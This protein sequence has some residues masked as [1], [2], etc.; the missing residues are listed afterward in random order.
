M[1]RAA[2]AGLSAIKAP[3]CANGSAFAP[4]PVPDEDALT[5]VDP[6]TGQPGTHLPQS[7]DRYVHEATVQV[8]FLAHTDPH[9]AITPPAH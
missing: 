6:L 7:D 4:I 1:A 2:S 8:F 3:D 9:Q 5:C